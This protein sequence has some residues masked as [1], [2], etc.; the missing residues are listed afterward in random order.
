HIPGQRGRAVWGLTVGGPEENHA[1][2]VR[3]EHTTE[4]LTAIDRNGP[5]WIAVVAQRRGIEERP[6]PTVGD[7]Q[8]L[9][10]GGEGDAD[11][12]SQFGHGCE[13]ADGLCLAGTEVEDAHVEWEQALKD[14]W[15]V[16]T[17]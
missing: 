17:R 5:Q 8:P 15:H 11:I 16:T 7:G 2:T 3:S 12:T 4:L 1:S 13:R 9:P 14:E 6:L 10:V